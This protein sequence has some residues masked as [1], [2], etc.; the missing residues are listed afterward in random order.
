V[1]LRSKTRRQLLKRISLAAVPA[2]LTACESS[3]DAPADQSV[4]I[5][6]ST[7]T[8]GTDN[9]MPFNNR[10]IGITA[11]E[12]EAGDFGSDVI[13]RIQGAGANST[14]LSVYWDDIEPSAG[15]FSPMPNYLQIAELFYAPRGM[16]VTLSFSV[17]DT[18]NKRLPADLTGRAFDDAQVIARFKSMLDWAASQL[19][20]LELQALVIGNEVDI[21]LNAHTNEWPAW[22]TFFAETSQHARNL[23]P[24]TVVGCKA[25]YAGLTAEPSHSQLIELNQHSSA[26]LVTYYH[27]GSEFSVLT[28]DAIHDVFDTLATLPDEQAIHILELGSPTDALIGGSETHQADV[29]S[30][31]FRAWDDHSTR[32]AHIEFFALHDFSQSAVAQ[33]QTYYSFPDE[34][35]AAYLGSLGLRRSAGSGTD[36]TA[37]NRLKMEISARVS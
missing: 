22:Q 30:E 11:T 3:D 21:Y 36:K 29:I 14:S 5:P 33:L 6:G 35:F 18:T 23:W 19:P 28:P 8:G 20:T 25:T 37:W 4:E 34:R 31:A 16:Q 7:N 17:I 10:S 2:V 9:A 15:V 13:D 26:V 27:I 12:P 32:I 24:N 1:Q